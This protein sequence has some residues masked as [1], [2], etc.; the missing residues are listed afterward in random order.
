MTESDDRPDD[1]D[2]AEHREPPAEHPEQD[3]E[4]R[5]DHVDPETQITPDKVKR[6]QGSG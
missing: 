2:S 1:R 5:L 4:S 3:S 6:E